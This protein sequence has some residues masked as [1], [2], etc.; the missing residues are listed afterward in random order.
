M[1]S[2]TPFPGPAGVNGQ[3]AAS[4]G[5]ELDAGPDLRALLGV[6][7][8]RRWFLVGAL[9]A[10]LLLGALVTI[11]A[12]RIFSARALM[13]IERETPEV[14][15]GV[16]EV[17]DLGTGS[18]WNAQEY[19]QT[20]YE[21]IKS[22]PVAERAAAILGINGPSLL[23]E[24]QAAGPGSTQSA[25]A[26]DPLS[27]LP[28]E[29]RRKLERLGFG[30]ARTRETLDEALGKFDGASF[31]RGKVL[32]NP[33]KDSRLVEIAVEDRDPAFAADVANAVAQ[34]YEEAN[35]DQ[36][37]AFTGTAVD[38]LTTQVADLKQKLED[39]EIRLHEFKKAN[40]IVSVSL[41]DKRT[42]TAET[43]SQLNQSLST[44]KARRLDLE[45][46]RS[47]IAR[48]R[49]EG[50]EAV[51]LQEIV[52][53]HVVQQLKLKLSELKQEDAE[54]SKRYMPEHPKAVAVRERLNMVRGDLEAEI[55]RILKSLEGEYKQAVDTEA[56]LGNAIEEVKQEALEL[57]KKEIDYNR[58]RRERDNNQ[59]L[60]D[61]VLKREKEASLTRML[62][63]N[64]VRRHE[65]AREPERPV[66]PR[67]A[68]NMLV[69][70]ILG[71]LGGVGLAFLVD[72]LDN[73]VKTQQQVEHL[74]GLPFLGVVPS[75][76]GE[77]RKQTMEVV[78]RDHYMIQN[79][80]S[81]VAECC[82]TIRTNLLF[83]SP[84]KEL[85]LLLITSGGPR[86]G[87]ST[88]VVALATTMAQAG[89]RVVVV[90]SDMRRPRLHKSFNLPNEKGLS[91]AILGDSRLDQA[92]LHTAVP[93]VD[94][95]PCGPI[96]PNPAELLHTD[97]FRGVLRD[98][99][100]SYDRVIFDSPPVGAVTDA[101]VLGSMVDGVI[102]VV[103][104]G[105]TPWPAAQQVKRRLT[106]VNA[107]L[108]GVVLNDVDL[109]ARRAGAYYQ[110]YYYYYRYGED[111][112]GKRR[113]AV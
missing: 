38:W 32:V 10:A 54:I 72:Y 11:R 25:L 51:T 91:T 5:A 48:A 30:R 94:L 84:E 22:R 12:P 87:K 105:A 52:N 1:S 57:N 18:Y 112:A 35:L 42:M 69:A 24:L 88:V 98:L 26:A 20:Q 37:I 66:R 50:L 28:D 2:L 97:S 107:R 23:A 82:R 109:D 9:G 73:T 58:L 53:S 27:G 71:L 56:R 44:T 16:R 89:S 92:I 104:A 95:L 75:I 74:L 43:L 99:S 3:G 68:L 103:K 63:V 83:M 31:V 14:L 40:N 111:D 61:M 4:P 100:A 46:Q 93:G 70:L 85:K 60:Y 78:E 13:L 8:R 33:I 76:H 67:V 21:I 6:L 101:T 55:D 81:S 64:N 7:L 49:Q 59:A 62:K 96:P 36:K 102:M 45:S 65:A 39:S 17:Y 77:N 113:R 110:Q 29:L 34:A 15:S 106:D 41:E 108:L 90:D 47:R 86:E 19:Y 79:P 80:R